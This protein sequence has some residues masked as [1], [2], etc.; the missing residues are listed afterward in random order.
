[1]VGDAVRRRALRALAAKAVRCESSE[2]GS[3]GACTVP[4][5]LGACSSS[6]GAGLLAFHGVDVGEGEAEQLA[7]RELVREWR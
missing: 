7:Y 5:D 3:P 2:G 1:M 6:A 4:E